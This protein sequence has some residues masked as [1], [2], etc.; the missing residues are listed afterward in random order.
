MCSRPAQST[1]PQDETEEEPAQ[2][3]G[4]KESDYLDEKGDEMLDE[5]NQQN[6]DFW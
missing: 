2:R 6:F 4:E 3:G 1:P 5:E